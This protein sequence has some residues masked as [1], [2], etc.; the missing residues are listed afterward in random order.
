MAVSA[1][2]LMF[3]Q[4]RCNAALD[5]WIMFMMSNDFLHICTLIMSIY[6]A[7][8]V[9]QAEAQPRRERNDNF[10][11]QYRASNLSSNVE[12]IQY[13]EDIEQQELRNYDM[14]RNYEEYNKCYYW[15]KELVK[16]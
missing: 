3:Y 9:G 10:N 12:N 4:K 1:F 13:Q 2:V 14:L 6:Y 15:F 8:R 7:T 5:L 16:M 11:N